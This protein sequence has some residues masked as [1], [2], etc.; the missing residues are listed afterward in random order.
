MRRQITLATRRELTTAI[1]Q[2]YMAAD[3][4]GKKLILDEFVKVTKYHRKHA[5]RLLTPQ[6]TTHEGRPVGRRTYQE[7]P[8]TAFAERQRVNELL[9]LCSTIFAIHSPR[10]WLKPALT[11]QRSLPSSA[12]IPSE[13]CNGTFTPPQSTSRAQCGG[14]KRAS[15]RSIKEIQAAPEGLSSEAGFCPSAL[16]PLSM[17]IQANSGRLGT[18]QNELDFLR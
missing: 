9:T 10:E 7:A 11:S 15:L 4:N 16:G 5:I 17:P 14:L 3:Q 6:Q 12:T 1:S 13:S 18:N 8:T 2:R